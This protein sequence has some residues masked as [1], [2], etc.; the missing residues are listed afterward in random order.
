MSHTF[1]WTEILQK[2]VV[3]WHSLVAF[4]RWSCRYVTCLF[5]H[6]HVTQ[7]YA[8]PLSLFL[9]HSLWQQT[10]LMS[11]DSTEI[12]YVICD[13]RVSKSMLQAFILW[14]RMF[15]LEQRNAFYLLVPGVSVPSVVIIHVKRYVLCKIWFLLEARNTTSSNKITRKLIFVNCVNQTFSS[16]IHFIYRHQYTH[17]YLLKLYCVC[18]LVLFTDFH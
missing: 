6:W 1:L 3:T 10:E 13:I 5:L 8:F 12:I 9:E 15:Y 14:D 18:L 7:L 4:H 11:R 17:Y 2:V 16:W